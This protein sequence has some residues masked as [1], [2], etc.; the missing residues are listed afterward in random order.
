VPVRGHNIFWGSK[1]NKL[2]P[3]EVIKM[4]ANELKHAVDERIRYVVNQTKGMIDHWD[5]SNEMLH[6]HYFEEK[7]GDPYYSHHMYKYLHQ[8]D[9]K[10]KLFLNDYNII[11][12]GT[13]TSAFV[14]QANEYKKANVGLYGLGIQCH[15]PEYEKPD[16]TLI[17][18]RLDQMATTGLPLWVTELDVV[19]ADENTRADWYDITLRSLFS[20][21]AV[22]GIILWD[23]YG[24]QHWR[25]PD[26]GLVSDL[27][28][29]V[30]AAGKHY[31]DLIYQEWNTHVI[32]DLGNGKIFSVRGFHGDYEVIVKYKGS[33]IKDQKF[34]LTKSDTHVDVTV[35]DIHGKICYSH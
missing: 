13:F 18:K 24:P 23:F 11:P 12:Q 10:P 1:D 5:V 31:L 16:A 30:N 32:H 26:A 29:R 19:V 8:L 22:E 35:T 6:N 14:S 3:D 28:Y 4:N 21:P 9:P 33:P 17:K 25:G 15:F 34:T 7:T 2:Q 20:H 27:D